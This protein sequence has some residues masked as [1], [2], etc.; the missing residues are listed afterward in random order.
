[1]FRSMICF[2]KF[3]SVRFCLFL[4]MKGGDRRLCGVL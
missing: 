2:L 3:V 1:M 4:F